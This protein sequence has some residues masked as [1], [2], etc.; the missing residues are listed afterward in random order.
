MNRIDLNENDL[1][2]E[3]FLAREPETVEELLAMLTEGAIRVTHL[4]TGISAIGEGQG[5]QVKNK[6]MAIERLRTLLLDRGQI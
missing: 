3:I 5:N 1:Q 6:E 4:P 2:T